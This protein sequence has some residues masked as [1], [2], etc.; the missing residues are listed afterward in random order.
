MTDLRGAGDE[1]QRQIRSILAGTG[2]EHTL[3]D[4]VQWAR[5]PRWVLASQI[6]G[7]VLAYGGFDPWPGVE[8]TPPP[9]MDALARVSRREMMNDPT[10]VSAV[11]DNL[12][13]DGLL[14][15]MD[16]YATRN[17][18]STGDVLVWALNPADPVPQQDPETFADH[19]VSVAE[20]R[21]DR[22]QQ[23]QDWTPR[24]LLVKLLREHDSGKVVL[25]GLVAAY[26]DVEGNLGFWNATKN[27]TTAVG[28]A[29]MAA[30][31]IA[32]ASTIR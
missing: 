20:V 19:P 7:L 17:D 29:S 13:Q 32:E 27:T 2:P 5:G 25:D 18:E 31:S 26:V 8:N 4:L 12:R 9:H 10:A 24:D 23:S 11:I 6:T 22:S 14:A 15:S 21:S 28:L 3:Q 16:G 1:R 30:T